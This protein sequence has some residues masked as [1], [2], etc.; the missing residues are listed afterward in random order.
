[1]SRR[2][3]GNRATDPPHRR[4]AARRASALGGPG[5]PSRILLE[6]P[7]ESLAQQQRGL[8]GAHGRSRRQADGRRPPGD[9]RSEPRSAALGSRSTLG[10]LVPTARTQIPRRP[11]CA[12]SG[13]G[14]VIALASKS[15]AVRFF[16]TADGKRF[17]RFR[18]IPRSTASRS[19]RTDR[20]LVSIGK[21]LRAV[22]WDVAYR[23]GSFG[24]QA[25]DSQRWSPAQRPN[26]SGGVH[27]RWP[28]VPA[29]W[30]SRFRPFSPL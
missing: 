17:V 15:G 19:A 5:R 23:A 9:R 18:L 26:Q 6:V 16:D 13:D 27:A 22:L 30:T 24:R 8:R 1:M 21:D 28:G 14:R 2:S 29:G 3:S 11:S 4:G 20:R 10:N 7:V 25:S 12:F